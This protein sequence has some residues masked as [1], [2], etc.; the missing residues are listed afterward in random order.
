MTKTAEMIIEEDI[1]KVY[2]GNLNTVE[3]DLKLPLVGENGS[4]ITWVSDNEL[5][6]RPDGSVTRP[7]NGIGD[8]KVHLHACFEYGGLSKEKIYEV[9]I[10]EEPRKEKIVEALP[11]KEDSKKR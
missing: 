5:F 11:F 7:W 3:F 8:R 10:L 2:L 9:H 6:L 4:K 1:R